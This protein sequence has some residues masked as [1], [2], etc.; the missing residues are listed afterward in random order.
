MFKVILVGLGQIGKL[1]L[2]ILSQLPDFDVIAVV[3]PKEVPCDF[4]RYVSIEECNNHHQEADLYVIATPNGLHYRQAKELLNLGKNVLIEKP[5]AL[6]KNQVEEL[7]NLAKEKHLRLF[8]SLQL[9]FSPV[10]AYVKKLIEEG[11][12]GEIFMLSVECFWNRNQAYYQNHW[13][14]TKDMDGGVLFTQ[15]SHFVDIIHFFLDRIELLHSSSKNFTHQD[16]T[17]FPDSGIL[18]FK[19]GN[20]LGSMIYTTSAYEKNYDSS[21]TII[22][23][24]GT[25]K[26]GG[27]YMNQLLY[28][29]VE[30]ICKPEFDLSSHE[31]HKNLYENILYSI[32]NNIPSVADAENS[33]HTIGFIEQANKD[34]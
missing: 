26:I 17:D 14:G 23:E 20:T 4:P 10:V 29:N 7:V 2:K 18:Q 6:Y 34:I 21:L 28:H 27:Q 24:K 22:A 33:I 3:E 19:A 13:H 11:T 30:G 16:C 1:H 15:F 25:I 9:R 32:K 8:S 31:F 12:L 5:A